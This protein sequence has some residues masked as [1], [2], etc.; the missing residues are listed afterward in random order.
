MQTYFTR[1]NQ[2]QDCYKT[3]SNNEWKSMNSRHI[4][5]TGANWAS[6]EAR[7]VEWGW[8]FGGAASNNPSSPARGSSTHFLDSVHLLAF[9]QSKLSQLTEHTL[10]MTE[11]FFPVAD[12]CGFSQKWG[13]TDSKVRQQKTDWVLLKWHQTTT[14]SWAPTSNTCVK[15]KR[16]CTDV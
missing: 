9:K 1:Y 11:I 6:R 4:Q 16:L 15:P 8:S 12:M 3:T 2:I 7:S 13:D 10:M 5:D 14:N